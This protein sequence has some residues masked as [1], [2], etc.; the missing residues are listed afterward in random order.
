MSAQPRR[1]PKAPKAGRVQRRPPKS[2]TKSTYAPVS[3][4]TQLTSRAPV[5]TGG[6]FSKDG[7]TVIRHREYIADV[8]GSVNFAATSYAVNPGVP[9]TFPWLSRYLAPGYETYKFRYLRFTYETSKSTASSGSVLL[10]Y[11]YDAADSAPT[12]K[13]T[14][15]SFGGAVR[16]ACWAPVSAVGSSPSLNKLPN[17]YVRLGTLAANLD[18]KT[19]DC[20]NFYVATQGCADT[21][22]MGELYVDY[23]VELDNPQMDLSATTTAM[24]AKG[25]CSTGV[26][27]TT[28]F[29][30]AAVITGGLPITLLNATYTCTV[31]GQYLFTVWLTGTGFS[32]GS[33]TTGLVGTAVL[34][35]TS[36]SALMYNAA[37]TSAMISFILTVVAPGDGGTLDFTNAATTVTNTVFRIGPYAAAIA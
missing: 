26:A 8:S 10:A 31:P 1:L 28:P 9:T 36:F 6:P 37:A 30:S 2:T 22:V 23:I 35:N 27:R 4:T 18:I 14:M 33:V 3:M 25:V 19:Y 5:V 12:T 21:T 16:T 11:D 7:K 13:Q 24:S 17:R 15:M 32:A 20:A 34:A 29:G